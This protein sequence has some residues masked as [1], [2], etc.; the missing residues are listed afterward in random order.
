MRLRRISAAT[1]AALVALCLLI[2]PIRADAQCPGQTT[3]AKPFAYESATVSTVAVTLTAATYAPSGQTQ[4]AFA[5][6]TVESNPLR[7]RID[8]TAPTSIE[9]HAATDGGFLTVC[10]ITAIK[11][12]S[13]IRSG[14]TDA[15]VRVTYY[16]Q[17]S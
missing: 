15:K 10:G 6:I 13:A 11:N 9:G 16:R 12:F 3:T 5:I 7:Y 2:E 17:G 8:G 4:A 14:G 1:I